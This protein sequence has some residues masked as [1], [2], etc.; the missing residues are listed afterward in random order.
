ML[1][2]H[3]FTVLSLH[4][5]LRS[6]LVSFSGRRSPDCGN[7]AASSAVFICCSQKGGS[8]NWT[9]LT[10]GPESELMVLI[11]SR[12]HRWDAVARES[13]KIF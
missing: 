2:R 11:V 4:S 3:G 7:V 9:V 5:V 10:K 8:F 1:L 6:A 13:S 12:A